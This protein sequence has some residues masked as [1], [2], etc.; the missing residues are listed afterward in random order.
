MKFKWM[1]WDF[2]RFIKVFSE[3]KMKESWMEGG[4]CD[5]CC[6]RCR[7]YESQGNIIVT[8]ANKD[9]SENRSCLSC[10]YKW[11]A[12]FTPAGFIPME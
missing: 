8:T 6:P 2:W 5:S 11:T 1:K 4:N 3:K 10:G 9:G 12:I 7:Y